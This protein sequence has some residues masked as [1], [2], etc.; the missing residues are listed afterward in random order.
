[1]SEETAEEVQNVSSLEEK[2]Q[3]VGGGE[4]EEELVF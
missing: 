1:M 2:N 3:R 4:E